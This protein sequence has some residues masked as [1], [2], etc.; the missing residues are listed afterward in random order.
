MA[1]TTAGGNQVLNARQS[2]GL[3]AQLRKFLINCQPEI[4]T[5]MQGDDLP[6]QGISPKRQHISGGMASISY[7]SKAS[8]S[9][10]QKTHS[11]FKFTQFAE[12]APMRWFGSGFRQSA[13]C[14]MLSTH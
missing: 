14:T 9:A 7:L 6:L 3:I 13:V 12:I 2:N 10:D 4:F 5:G 11:A 1:I 8:E